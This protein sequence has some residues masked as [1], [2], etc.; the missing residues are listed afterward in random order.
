MGYNWYEMNLEPTTH[1]YIT[2]ALI[3]A[4][5][6]LVIYQLILTFKHIRL[7]K[8]YETYMESSDGKNIEQKI[9]LYF[10][11]VNILTTNVKG[12]DRKLEELTNKNMYNFNKVGF[13]R[14]SAFADVGSDLSFAMALMDSNNN[15]FVLSSIYA[16]NDNRIYAKP[17]ENGKS[18][19]RLSEEEELAIK[20]A[21]ES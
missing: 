14:F 7:R 15:G 20:K 19:Y 5:T 21:I 12:L 1:V 3:I 2:F 11:E 17:L 9:D 16:R 18:E 13:V 4:M 10:K 8:K 6:L